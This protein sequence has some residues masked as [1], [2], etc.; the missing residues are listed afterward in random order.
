MQQDH[1]DRYDCLNASS[2][3][4]FTAHFSSSNSSPRPSDPLNCQHLHLQRF[5][6]HWFN[7]VCSCR[8]F[9]ITQ[10]QTAVQLLS[11]LMR[12]HISRCCVFLTKT[13]NKHAASCT[14]MTNHL[15]H[16]PVLKIFVFFGQSAKL[17][18]KMYYKLDD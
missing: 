17:M 6:F 8:S 1:L 5:S 4:I 10:T 15:A 18:I 12:N 14:T 11:V 2:S 7:S 13:K 16:S 3:S 9:S